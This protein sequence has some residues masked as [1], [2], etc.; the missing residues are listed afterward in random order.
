MKPQKT[1]TLFGNITAIIF[2]IIGMGAIWAPEMVQ[3]EGI[4]KILLTIALLL[5][6]TMFMS[7]MTNIS[8]PASDDEKKDDK[9]EF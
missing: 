7:M 9:K 5:G 6:A 1:L 3:N 2:I 8:S 4:M